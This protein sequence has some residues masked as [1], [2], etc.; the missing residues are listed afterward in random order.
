[1]NEK[2]AAGRGKRFFRLNIL[3][4]DPQAGTSDS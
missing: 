1:M 2:S 3:K 4:L